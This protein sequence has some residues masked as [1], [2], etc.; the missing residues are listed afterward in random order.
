MTLPTVI[1]P[2]SDTNQDKRLM[3]YISLQSDTKAKDL[4][5]EVSDCGNK[6]VIK[7][8]WPELLF[9]P[10]RLLSRYMDKYVHPEYDLN[11][12]VVAIFLYS[13]PKIEDKIFRPSGYFY[14]PHSPAFCS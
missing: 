12:I 4:N 5:F 6:L 1:V 9:N 14:L 3:L 10:E 11:Y 7:Q 13:N 8:V 2:Y